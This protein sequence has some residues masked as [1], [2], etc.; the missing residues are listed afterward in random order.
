LKQVGY[1]DEYVVQK[2]ID[3]GRIRYQ[4][5][6]VG[7]RWQRL[8]KVLDEVEEQRLDDE[9]SD[10]HEGEVRDRTIG[11]YWFLTLMYAGH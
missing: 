2:L 9:M 6:T 8:K 10:W 1:S 7:S 5:K 11:I 3:E 4:A